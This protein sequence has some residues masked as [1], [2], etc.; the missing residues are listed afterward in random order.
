MNHLARSMMVPNPDIVGF[1]P[2]VLKQA[3]AH[4]ERPLAARRRIG[5]DRFFDLHYAALMR[6]P[7]G[8]MRELYEWAG[9]DLA[10]SVE[11][12][13]HRWLDTHP[14]DR[15]GMKPYSLDAYGLTISDLEPLYEEYLSTFGI[16]LEGV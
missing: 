12:A 15:F 3:R 11:T 1:V 7:I 16:E 10:P 13:M 6:D 2:T 9:D 4:V 5:D 8:Q 14:Q